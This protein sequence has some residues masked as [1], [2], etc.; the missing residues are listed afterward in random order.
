MEFLPGVQLTPEER[1]RRLRALW[2]IM[3]ELPAVDPAGSPERGGNTTLCDYRET[4]INMLEK[5]I[6]YFLQA[7]KFGGKWPM[8]NIFLCWRQQQGSDRH[9]GNRPYVCAYSTAPLG[10]II[11]QASVGAVFGTWTVSG[12]LIVQDLC[13]GC[14]VLREK[15][16]STWP[17]ALISY[18]KTQTSRA[19]AHNSFVMEMPYLGWN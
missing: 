14:F 3:T 15:S 9:V 7:V 19:Q 8:T 11:S 1:V 10:H 4:Q 16:T 5:N 2:E 18:W 17:E 12:P 13:R 6:L